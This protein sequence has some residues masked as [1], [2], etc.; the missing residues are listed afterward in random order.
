M[1]ATTVGSSSSSSS[2]RSQN[3]SS[4]SF[5]GA[6]NSPQADPVAGPSRSLSISS[7]KR[8][9][10]SSETSRKGKER[11]F[12]VSDPEESVPEESVNGVRKIE[13]DG[14]KNEDLH[15]S[16]GED[17]DGSLDGSEE[18]EEEPSVR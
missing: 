1:S 17:E 4:K 18:D 16:P 14:K 9:S 8:S 12:E 5:H 3:T 11:A 7:R 6:N 10:S 15:S 2:Q 13:R